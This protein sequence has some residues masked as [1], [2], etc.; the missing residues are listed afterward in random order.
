MTNYK[1]IIAPLLFA[2][3]LT[4]LSLVA[5][6]ESWTAPLSSSGFDATDE[7]LSRPFLL[8]W[9][10]LANA[11]QFTSKIL[12]SSFLSQVT[13]FD[14]EKALALI[15]ISRPAGKKNRGSKNS[16]VDFTAQQNYLDFDI[17]VFYN[18]RIAFLDAP[19]PFAGGQSK[20]IF[21]SLLIRFNKKFDIKFSCLVAK[22][23]FTGN[24]NEKR[25]FFMK[26]ELY[27]NIRSKSSFLTNSP[28]LSIR[29]IATCYT[30]LY[31]G[32]VDAMFK[33]LSRLSEK[34]CRG[35]HYS[36]SRQTFFNAVIDFADQLLDGLSFLH[37][38][39]M[40]HRDLKPQNILYI[41]N[42]NAKTALNRPLHLVITDFDDMIAALR[43]KNDPKFL[44]TQR[45]SSPQKLHDDIGYALDQSDD[46]YAVG[47]IMWELLNA[48][49][50]GRFLPEQIY[51]DIHK[52]FKN[53]NSSAIKYK[54]RTGEFAAREKFRDV[55]IHAKNCLFTIEPPQ[56]NL[57]YIIYHLTLTKKSTRWNASRALKYLRKYNRQIRDSFL[58]PT[59]SMSSI[60]LKHRLSFKKSS[61]AARVKYKK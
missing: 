20:R 36:L 44:G 46:N 50:K 23:E 41:E 28:F 56:K 45:Y 15:K 11:Y 1:S 51:G 32:D 5:M 60:K 61:S 47:V 9:P 16:Y 37:A 31:Q 26:N 2:I 25:I 33:D 38:N 3:F 22:I 34:K 35:E 7:L 40:V 8:T 14:I 19:K 30:K 39:G 4:N 29:E 59:R 21:Y 57:A 18:Q 54:G 42:T 58:R 55:I 17:R 43:S 48:S 6:D 24:K 52:Y 10:D 12:N 13:Q 27:R 53:K 49:R